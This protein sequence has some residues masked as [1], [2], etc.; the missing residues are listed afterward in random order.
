MV[1]RTLC[2]EGVLKESHKIIDRKRLGLKSRIRISLIIIIKNIKTN[3]WKLQKKQQSTKE[4]SSK[5]LEG[6]IKANIAKEEE[7]IP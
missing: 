4:C 2:Q 6:I 5:G 3:C 7:V 1:K